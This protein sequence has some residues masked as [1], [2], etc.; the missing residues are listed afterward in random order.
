LNTARREFD[1]IDLL[2]NYIKSRSNRHKVLFNLFTDKILYFR[3]ELDLKKHTIFCNKR[4]LYSKR[5]I[6][7]I[8]SNEDKIWDDLRG[9]I[10]KLDAL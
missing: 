9:L 2:F 10:K 8:N 1:N 4:A 7:F 6:F 5:K 3:V